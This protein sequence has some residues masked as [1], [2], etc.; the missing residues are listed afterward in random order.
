MFNAIFLNKGKD[1]ANLP[2]AHASFFQIK[3]NKEE[4]AKDY[5]SRVDKAVSDLAILNEKISTNSWRFI[6]ANGLRPE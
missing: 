2:N 5:I 3:M 6:M 1:Q 4:T